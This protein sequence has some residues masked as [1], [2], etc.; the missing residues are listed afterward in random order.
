MKYNILFSVAA[1]ESEESLIDLIENVIK[2]IPNSFIIIHLKKG[3]TVNNIA[4]KYPNI[5]FNTTSFNTGY[6]DQSLTIVHSSNIYYAIDKGIDADFFAVLGSNEL[7]VRKGLYNHI[8]NKHFIAYQTDESDYHVRIARRDKYFNAIL[9]KIGGDLIKSPPEGAFYEFSILKEKLNTPYVKEYIDK[10]S[11]YFT[12]SNKIIFRK[13]GGKVARL[14]LHFIPSLNFIIP[15]TIIRFAYAGE[16]IFFPTLMQFSTSTKDNS[17]CYI[18]WHEKLNIEI[19][20]IV[21]VSIGKYP[22][23]YSVKRIKRNISD[24]KRIWIKNKIN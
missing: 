8:K 13:I 21:D 7:F 20:D 3:F 5:C 22:E 6:L 11:L 15:S 18:K 2:F 23:K 17:Y 12:S 10:L 9:K 1:H 4:D 16:E 24:P 19:N 14:I